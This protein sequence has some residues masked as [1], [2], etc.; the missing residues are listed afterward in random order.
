METTRISTKK[1]VISGVGDLLLGDIRK[2]VWAEDMNRRPF[3]NGKDLGGYRVED[4]VGNRGLE[5]SLENDLRGLRG[6]VVR[7]RLGEELERIPPVGGQDVQ[8]TL[9]IKLQAR[10]EAI[11]TTQIGLMMASKQIRS[12]NG[13][14]RRS[15]RA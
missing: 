2:K 9:D 15:C 4:E 11:L 3:D 1:I 6:R 13:S 5:L 7:D 8:L 10:I 14:S 12:W